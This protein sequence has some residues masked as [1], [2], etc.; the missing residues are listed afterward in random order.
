[1]KREIKFRGK[2][3]DNKKWIYGDL[4]HIDKSDIGI[5]TDYAHWQGCRVDPKTVGQFTGLLDRN[6]KEIYEGDILALPA[7]G[8]EA[9]FEFIGWEGLYPAYVRLY[10]VSYHA[11]DC[12]FG[13]CLL[14]EALHDNPDICGLAG[15]DRMYILGN[16]HDN[17]ELIK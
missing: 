17:P 9:E 8:K 11:G 12:G 5:V 2:R 14:H 15:H 1:M 16:I 4:I 10:A 3:L 13:L 7:N 6:G